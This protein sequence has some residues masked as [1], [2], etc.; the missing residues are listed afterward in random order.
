MVWLDADLQ[1]QAPA[2]GRSGRPAVFSD[3]AIQLCL[4]L[5]CMFGLGL[6]QATGLA[7]SLIKL[8]RLNWRV[9][10]YSTLS[11]RQKTL[12]VAIAMRRSSAGLHLLIDSTSVK[13]LGEGEWKTKKHKADYRRQWR[14]VHLGIYAQTLEIRAIE[15]T[16]GLREGLEQVSRD[17][18]GSKISPAADLSLC[19]RRMAVARSSNPQA[20]GASAEF[21]CVSYCP[22]RRMRA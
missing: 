14:K 3:A 1:W 11:R 5:K 12:S 7:E 22:G 18:Q 20:T 4:T 19:D 17:W 6:R 15:I 16:Y 2:S 8:A 10:D 13:M 21:D 9:P